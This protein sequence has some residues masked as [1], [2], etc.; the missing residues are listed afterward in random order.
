[1][2]K[3]FK[4]FS[5]A[6]AIVA[7]SFGVATAVNAQSG[8][9]GAKAE[10]VTETLSTFTTIDGN[11][12]LDWKYSTVANTANAPAINSGALRLYSVRATGEGNILTIE[13]QSTLT[14]KVISKVVFVFA[15]TTDV[16]TYQLKWG[17]STNNLINSDART[18]SKSGSSE[19]VGSFSALTFKNTH[20]GGSKNLQIHI[21]S[22]SITYDMGSSEPEVFGTLDHIDLD[23]SNVKTTFMVGDT[24]DSTGLVVT[25]VDEKDFEEPAEGF[26]TNLVGYEFLES[27]L[28][29]KTITVSYGGKTANYTITV[30]PFAPQL[31]LSFT[32]ST[33]TTAKTLEELNTEVKTGS[34]A[35]LFE[36]ISANN[37]YVDSTEPSSL[38]LSSGSVNAN[39]ELKLQN[40][41]E[42]TSV[43]LVARRWTTD[44]TT[45]NVNKVGAQN[46]TN[47]DNFANFVFDL[48]K[49][50]QVIEVNTVKRAFIKEIIVTYTNPAK[51]LKDLVMSYESGNVSTPECADK[52]LAAKAKWDTLNP[53]AQTYFNTDASF[54]EAHARLNHWALVNNVI[55]TVGS[56]S[57]VRQPMNST[58]HDNLVAV[59]AIGL[60]GLTSVLGYYFIN[61]KKQ[62]S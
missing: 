34:D 33:S 56:T 9:V 53:D 16:T 5:T 48:T 37:V 6:I 49:N 59:I 58:T 35:G 47:T 22:I 60:I 36:F 24:F 17:D 23:Y 13:P 3:L 15:S 29:T 20:T 4:K 44:A 38:K 32:G 10:T 25:A 2:R 27:D 55:L 19:I 21:A 7:M 30:V 28:G 39:F 43:T 57:G 62:I 12:G 52:F 14:T 45:L 54:A 50:A 42:A 41:L 31:K 61:K 40:G 1:M 51:E 18:T 8:V 11:L 46:V 26:T